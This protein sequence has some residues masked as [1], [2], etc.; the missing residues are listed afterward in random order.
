MNKTSQRLSPEAG[1]QPVTKVPLHQGAQTS[2]KNLKRSRNRAGWALV[3]PAMLVLSLVMLLPIGYGFYLS[4]TSYNPVERGAPKF[5]G[6]TGYLKVLQSSVFWDAVWVTFLY[7]AGTLLIAVPVAM[8]LA[9]LVNGS[10]PGVGVFRAVL[11]MPRVVPLV[12]AALIWM[13]LYSHDGFFNYVLEVFGLPGVDFLTDENTALLSLILMRSWKALGG[14]M[15]LFLAGLQ[16]VPSSLL[17]SA[18]VDG[19]GRM[20]KFWHV[21][22][23][24]LV[25]IITYVIVMDL[26]YL[27][28][29]FTE[30]YIMTSGGPLSSTKVVN[31]LVYEEAFQHYRLGDASAMA[32]VLFCL[33]FAVAYAN[34]R[35]LRRR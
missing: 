17:E 21:T 24:T 10:F 29:S 32:F 23:P 30:I 12:A 34:I 9:V 5:H 35:I 8:L 27:A 31:M 15:I 28:Q 13:W 1:G 4:L 19:C 18:S 16:S 6:V 22:L 20:R 11:Y 33:I 3:S 26:I 2:R 25:P 7:A 14:G